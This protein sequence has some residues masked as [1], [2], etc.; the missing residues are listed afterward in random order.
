M[1]PFS[2]EVRWKKGLPEALREGEWKA[3]HINYD[4]IRVDRE[5][6]IRI[7]LLFNKHTTRRKKFFIIVN[8]AGY[9]D[10]YLQRL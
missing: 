10:K 1:K 9:P 3:F 2:W 8:R 6:Y 7:N 5:I 4:N